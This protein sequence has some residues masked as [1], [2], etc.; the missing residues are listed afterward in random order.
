MKKG[1]TLIELLVV[2]AIIAILA[3]LLMPALQRARVQAQRVSCLNNL[4]QLSSSLALYQTDHNQKFPENNN[5]LMN[6]LI[7]GCGC[8]TYEPSD[9]GT[10]GG[11][12]YGQYHYYCRGTL[13]P[14]YVS[15]VMIVICP[16]DPLGDGQTLP[17]PD[18][19]RE[20]EQ[21]PNSKPFRYD[22]WGWG[23][24][25]YG[26]DP[27]TSIQR[28]S[29]FFSGQHMV[30]TE[31]MNQ[32]GSLRLMCDNEHEDDEY[33]C[34]GWPGCFMSN[35]YGDVNWNTYNGGGTC[36]LRSKRLQWG[37]QAPNEQDPWD[38]TA[39]YEFIGGL[40]KGDNHG[41]EGVNMLFGDLHAVF[42][43]AVQKETGAGD[44]TI[45][46]WIDPAGWMT[47]WTPDEQTSHTGIVWK[48]NGWPAYDWPIRIEM[49]QS[50]AL[51]TDA[52]EFDP[53]ATG[54][55][56]FYHDTVNAGR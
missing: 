40:E 27:L 18:T 21:Y 20:W 51:G 16:N 35:G 1:F 45:M 4:R 54:D 47:A 38:H 43:K 11:N 17:V 14:D 33:H 6:S 44:E 42:E 34:E 26:W 12:Q 49:E 9:T 7:G 23:Y 48:L 29:Y 52:Y 5:F 56:D 3:G 10:C 25:P 53:W 19:W 8:E 2:V 31:E 39:R 50:A 32:A 30:Q 15:D 36:F 55:A 41:D 13:W 24:A 37:V 46:A 22:H 28:F